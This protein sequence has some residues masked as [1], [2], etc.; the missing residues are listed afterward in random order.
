MVNNV[1][2]EMFRSFKKFLL[3]KYWYFDIHGNIELVMGQPKS[4]KAILQ[5]SMAGT[6]L[7]VKFFLKKLINNVIT[8]GCL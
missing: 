8:V 1:E 3:S 6:A 5:M 2:Y 7:P 4:M